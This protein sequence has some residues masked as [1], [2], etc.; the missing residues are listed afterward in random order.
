MDSLT[1]MTVANALANT[2]PQVAVAAIGSSLAFNLGVFIGC[3]LVFLVMII[4]IIE[5]IGI[6]YANIQNK[7][8]FEKGFLDKKI[9]SGYFSKIEE[10][11][12]SLKKGVKGV[13][14][15]RIKTFDGSKVFYYKEVHNAKWF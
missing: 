4:G 14:K 15:I 11:E 7:K 1:V 9:I 13:K 10:F 3:I 8:M 12:Y 2:T 6:T 5:L